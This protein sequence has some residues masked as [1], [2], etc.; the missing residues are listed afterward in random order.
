MG[1]QI[2]PEY[3]AATYPP[4]YQW[5]G[6]LYTVQVLT[7]TSPLAA[8]FIL[9][10]VSVSLL[11]AAYSKLLRLRRA[12]PKLA[13]AKQKNQNIPGSGTLKDMYG[14]PW[15]TVSFFLPIPKTIFY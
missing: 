15:Y 8:G 13:N 3:A 4:P 9:I 12:I 14:I 5:Q 10:H 7:F 11:S 2:G 6:G 1:D